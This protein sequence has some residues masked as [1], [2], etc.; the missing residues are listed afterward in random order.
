MFLF[1]LAFIT[2]QQCDLNFETSCSLNSNELFGE[3]P[4]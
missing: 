2:D 3:K 1:C 4:Y